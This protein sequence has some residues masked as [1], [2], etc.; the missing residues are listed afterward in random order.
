MPTYP[1]IRLKALALTITFVVGGG[2]TAGADIVRHNLD[3]VEQHDGRH[4]EQPGTCLDHQHACDLGL[5][6]A[7][8]KLTFPP[9]DHLQPNREA[10]LANGLGH[11]QIPRLL[12]LLRLPESRAPPQF[13]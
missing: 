3:L 7:G 2:S 5:S 12:T 9:R 13:G 11:S 6:V 4:I 10:R 1:S 8:P